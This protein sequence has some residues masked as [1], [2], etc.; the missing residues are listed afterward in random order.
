MCIFF[1]ATPGNA[2]PDDLI[3]GGGG[4]KWGS[5]KS[6]VGQRE[7]FVH[8]KSKPSTTQDDMASGLMGMTSATHPHTTMGFARPHMAIAEQEPTLNQGKW[9]DSQTNYIVQKN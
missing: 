6:I 1:Y 7:D 8:F 3:T 2:D 5:L 9:R 4:V